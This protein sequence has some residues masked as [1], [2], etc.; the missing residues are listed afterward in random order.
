MST[1]VVK[2]ALKVKYEARLR[3]MK[4]TFEAKFRKNDHLWRQRLDVHRQALAKQQHRAKELEAVVREMAERVDKVER[5]NREVM[6]IARKGTLEMR[7][8]ALQTSVRKRE[9]T[10]VF[11]DEEEDDDDNER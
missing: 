7:E 8:Q 4:K 9:R 6:A 2:Q 11:S 5:K 3:E 10:R 1:E